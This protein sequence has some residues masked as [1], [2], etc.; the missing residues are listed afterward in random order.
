MGAAGEG[1]H[2]LLLG[3][4]EREAALAGP[5]DEDVE[6][7]VGAAARAPAAVAGEAVG[8]RH[9][10]RFSLTGGGGRRAVRRAG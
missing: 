9:R 8:E 5:L 3:R 2:R 7:G 10:R 1:E 6:G 4:V